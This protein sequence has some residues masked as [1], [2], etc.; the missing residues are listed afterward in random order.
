[1]IWQRSGGGYDRAGDVW[2]LTN[3]ASHA[4]GQEPSLGRSAIG[5][6]FAALLLRPGREPELHVMEPV[7]TVDTGAIATD[8]IIAHEANLA[9]GLAERMTTLGVD[10]RVAYVGDD[11]LPAQIYRDLLD[12]TPQIEW[13][14]EGTLLYEIQRRK[15]DREL[16]L[17]R[18]AGAI[19]SDALT[20]L[21][22]GLIGGKR[23]S[24]AAADAASIIVAAGGGFQRVACHAGPRS[25]REMW[26]YPLYGYTR[27]AP[28]PGDLVRGF[29]YGPILEGY[30]LDPGRCS[31]CGGRPSHEQKRLIEDG[32]ELTQ[33]VIGAVRA[34]ATPRDAGIVGDRVT[35]ELGYGDD[36]GGAIWDIYGHGLGTFF[37]SPEIPAHG[38]QS[39]E[40]DPIWWRVDTPFLDG[41]VFTVETFLTQAGIGMTAF[42]EIFITRNDGV[43]ALIST[44]MLFW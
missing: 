7:H 21:M 44:P 33:A 27:E 36:T 8:N 32:V 29:V 43:E 9:L 14:P 26:N 13:V 30:W 41:E 20:A 31:V 28:T 40:N 16:D 1:V 23:Q 19:A 39:F 24:E 6:A 17:Y 4:S 25:E 2:Y 15:S 12:A 34:G 11:F 3:Y 37:S 10:G 38:A 22:E 35:I 5:R 42:E 18:H